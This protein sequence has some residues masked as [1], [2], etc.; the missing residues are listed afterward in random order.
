M[1]VFPFLMAAMALVTS[2]PALPIGATDPGTKM[3][4]LLFESW[5][6][7]PITARPW[8]LDQPSHMTYQRIHGGIEP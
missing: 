3:E 8:L 7:G 6:S 4:Q 5:D 1:S 2:S